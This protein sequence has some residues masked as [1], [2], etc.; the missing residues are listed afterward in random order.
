MKQVIAPLFLL[1][2]VAADARFAEVNTAPVSAG[3]AVVQLQLRQL[4]QLDVPSA[5]QSVV[6]PVPSAAIS[7]AGIVDSAANVGR[8]SSDWKTW[9]TDKVRYSAWYR[10]LSRAVRVSQPTHLRCDHI[11]PPVALLGRRCYLGMG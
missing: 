4:S 8:A 5:S 6:K 2:L 1:F 7:T 11:Q 10:S 9:L 3:Q